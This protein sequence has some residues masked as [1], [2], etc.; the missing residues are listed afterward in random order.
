[1]TH[2]AL[3]AGFVRNDTP[4]PG[5]HSEEQPLVSVIMNC[6]NCQKYLREAI[7]SV[8]RQ[9]YPHW[10]I[11]FWDNASTDD[12]GEIAQSYDS[13]L[14]YF[15]GDRTVPLGEARNLAMGQAKGQII[16]FLDCDDFWVETKLELQVPLFRNAEVGLVY[17]NY[18]L[19]NMN[20][21]RRTVHFKRKHPPQGRVFGKFLY[22][23]P[24]NM[25]TVLV[26]ANEEIFDT[27]LE[28]S[29]EFDYFLRILMQTEARYVPEPL[30]VYRFHDEMASQRLNHLYPVETAY[31]ID[32][33][34]KMIPDFKVRHRKGYERLRF[35]LNYWRAKVNMKDGNR[36]EA[37][38]N[39]AN[40]Q[41][42]GINKYAFLI[43]A[44]LGRRAWLGVHR[45]FMRY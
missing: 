15:R 13:R 8:Y 34:E 41:G 22:A 5:T 23:Y 10:E 43:L 33:F 2:Q 37:I 14:R 28:V 27:S 38:K 45:F 42:G 19:K 18:Y 3:P 12:S 31:I 17:S 40:S 36:E 11:I 1:M 39:L 4:F 44:V 26:R 32:K 20:T 35:K 9:T 7:D 30:A 21:G 25:Q 6:L 24:L 29:E 16:G